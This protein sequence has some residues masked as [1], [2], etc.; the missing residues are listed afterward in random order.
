MRTILF[1]LGFLIAQSIPEV[2][3]SESW[4]CTES[5]TR[6]SGTTIQ[7]CGVGLGADES[8]AKLKALA[9]AQ[10]EFNVL[11]QA[12]S[13]C[14][15]RPVFADP[16][17]TTC[18]KKNDKVE[19]RRMVSFSFVPKAIPGIDNDDSTE[20]DSPPPPPEEAKI[21]KGLSKREV[22]ARFGEPTQVLDAGNNQWIFYYRNQPFCRTQPYSSCSVVIKDNEVSHFDGF[23]YKNTN[24]LE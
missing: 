24:I 19:C 14:Q 12:S 10:I 18:E 20:L 17:R 23:Q 11:C 4:L 7:A 9:H 22:L 2:L 21:E 1:Y 13:D 15:G 3:A 8:E 16:K 6:R 5:S